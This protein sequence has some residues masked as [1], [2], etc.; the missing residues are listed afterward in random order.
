MAAVGFFIGLFETAP[1]NGEAITEMAFPQ[2]ERSAC[3]R[4]PSPASR[5]VM[6]GVIAA[7]AAL[8]WLAPQRTGH[9]AMPSCLTPCR[10]P[11]PRLKPQTAPEVTRD[12]LISDIHGSAQDQET[13]VE[14]KAEQATAA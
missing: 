1:E 6:V 8:R 11:I 7:A 13:P 5:Y 3:A 10:Q 2:A 9:S 14:S 12:G 4:F